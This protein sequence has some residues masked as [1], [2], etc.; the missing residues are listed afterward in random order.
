MIDGVGSFGGGADGSAVKPQI[1]ITSLDQL[2]F[3]EDNLLFSIIMDS[4]SYKT[5]HWM[6]YPPGTEYV[7]SYLESRGG[8]FDET[9]VFGGMYLIKKNLLGRV[10]T[11][12]MIDVA[13]AII[14][15]HMGGNPDL[16]NEAGW[17]YIVD[18]HDGHVPLEISMIP[19][20]TRIK[21]HNAIMQVVNTD[22]KCYWLVNYMETML[23]RMWYPTTVATLSH[24]LKNIILPYLEGT[25][26]PENIDF[27]VQDFGSR[28]STS[29]ESAAIG[30]SAHAV[31]FKGS[32]TMVALPL[33]IKYYKALE[34]PFFSVPAAEHSTITSWGMAFE[35]DA[36]RNLLTK[37]PSGIVSVVS[38]SFDIFNACKEI[39]G[40]QLKDLVS[41]RDGVVVIRPDSGDIISTILK[42]LD[43]LSD[44]FGYEVNSKGYK[45]LPK[46][47]RLLQGDGMNI[48]TV[49]SLFR[50]L[51]DAGWSADNLAC[52][53][54]GGKLLQ[55]VDRDTLKFAFKCSA[56]CVNGEWHDVWK[57]PVTDPGKASKRGRLAVTYY[58]GRNGFRT[59]TKHDKRHFGDRLEVVFRDGK[60]I[61][62][63]TFAEIRANSVADNY[64]IVIKGAANLRD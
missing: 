63:Y 18:Q 42:C 19:E 55:S 41:S 60:L 5:S 34:M 44:R 45:V 17:R 29:K 53:G 50:A 37:Y 15:P 31:N 59:V 2:Q 13:K 21:T 26:T 46:F 47:V 9:I 24:E 12:E 33:L 38:D 10:V 23:M 8:M 52:V 64:E 28:G 61:K 27:M 56:I 3:I 6:Q 11:H 20:G 22:P 48:H 1:S 36:I 54:M 35:L 25:G 30:A 4:D 57:D 51:K 14:V 58:G 16:F 62:E 49:R 7:S 43:I 40:T 39:F 32:D